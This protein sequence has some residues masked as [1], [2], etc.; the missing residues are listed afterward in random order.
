MQPVLDSATRMKDSTL[1]HDRLP[2]VQLPQVSRAAGD[3]RQRPLAE[4]Q[5]TDHD[6]DAGVDAVLIDPLGDRDRRR[7][8]RV[9]D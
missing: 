1:L 7:R 8:L 3:K 6:D 5:F 9:V 4:R 2:F